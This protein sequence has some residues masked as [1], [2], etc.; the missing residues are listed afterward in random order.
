MGQA[1]PAREMGGK[2]GKAVFSRHAVILLAAGD[3]AHHPIS[4]GAACHRFMQAGDNL[5]QAFL[6]EDAGRNGLAP[7]GFAGHAAD[8]HFAPLG[9]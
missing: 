4:A 6:A 9:E 7:G 2:L 3:G 8:G 5:W 1:N